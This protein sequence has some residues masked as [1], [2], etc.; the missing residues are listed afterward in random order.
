MKVRRILPFILAPTL[1]LTGCSPAVDQ[2]ANEAALNMG[3]A[4]PAESPS[5][6]EPDGEVIAFSPIDDI[7][8]TTDILAVRTGDTLRVGGLNAARSGDWKD[9]TIPAGAADVSANAGRFAVVDKSESAALLVDAATGNAEGRISVGEDVTV[10]AP[11]SD[12]GI[13]AG[14]DTKQQVWVYGSD[15][16]EKDSFGVAKGSDYVIAGSSTSDGEGADR[17]V[18]V[19]RFDTTIQDLHLDEGE[20]GGTLRVGL[21]VGKVAF[22]GDGLV[23]AADATGSRLL[24]YTTDEVIRLHQMVPTDGSPWAVAWDP[25]RQLA[26]VTSTAENTVTGYDISQGVP[27]EKEKFSTVAA[28]QSLAVLDD[29]TLI[30]GSA[31]G[32][33]LQVIAPTN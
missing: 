18:R 32:D 4:E 1:L 24:V 28:P 13:I 27:L 14:S 31:T 10:A 7:D 21:G 3:N 12:G 6:S 23:L 29:G 15:G 8:L 20:Q 25:A 22:G 19:N 11:L 30:I 9:T 33:G 16:A 26:W 5:A 2:K 17:V